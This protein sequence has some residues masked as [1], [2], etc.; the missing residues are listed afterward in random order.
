[1]REGRKLSTKTVWNNKNPE[2]N[3]VFNFIVDDPQQQSITVLLK[4]N[5]FPFS[6]VGLPAQVNTLKTSTEASLIGLSCGGH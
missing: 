6:K 5:D 4:D 1:M 2:Y 3:E